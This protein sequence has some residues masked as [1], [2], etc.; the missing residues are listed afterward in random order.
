MG[1]DIYLHDGDLNLHFCDTPDTPRSEH[2][3]RERGKWFDK[4]ERANAKSQ[5]YPEHYC[6][7]TYL[8]SSYNDGGFNSVVGNLIGKDFYSIFGSS[9]SEGLADPPRES[10]DDD[11]GVATETLTRE[12]VRVELAAALVRAREVTAELR[13]VK[14]PL[15]AMSETP[16]LLANRAPSVDKAR[17]IEIVNENLARNSGDGAY[18][19]RDG[20]F[21]LTEPLKVLAVIRGESFGQPAL[22]CVYEIDLTWYIQAAEICEEFIEYALTLENPRISWSS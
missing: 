19:N 1:L 14:R 10:D 4:P 11:G 15:R 22:H 18:S 20:V 6:E 7:R 2:G 13:G 16:T 8:R 5:K 21:F 12:Q 17:A 9:I 3:W